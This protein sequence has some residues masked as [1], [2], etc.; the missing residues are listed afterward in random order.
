M[1]IILNFSHLFII[2]LRTKTCDF[3]NRDE[4]KNS[5]IL[6]GRKTYLTQFFNV[7]NDG[8]TNKSPQENKIKVVNW[9]N[10]NLNF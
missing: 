8:L 2:C 4:N 5:L 6:Y 7:W 10:K 1:E 9:K 3:F